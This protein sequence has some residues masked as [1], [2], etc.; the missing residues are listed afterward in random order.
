MSR[1]VEPFLRSLVGLGLLHAWQV[2]EMIEARK[3]G[4]T[5]SYGDI[6]LDRRYMQ[7]TSIKRYIDYL[8]KESDRRAG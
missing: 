1:T 8:E 7:D 4:D 5:R 3:R 6:A 2:A